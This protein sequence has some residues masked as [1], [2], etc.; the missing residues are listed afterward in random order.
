MFYPKIKNLYERNEDG[1]IDFDKFSDRSFGNIKYWEVTEKLDGMNIKIEFECG[2]L[3]SR[4]PRLYVGGKTK[5]SEIPYSII[6]YIDSLNLIDKLFPLFGNENGNK[7]KKIEIFGEGIGP[8]IQNGSLYC[9][10]YKV[11]V[12]DILVDHKWWLDRENVLSICNK[13]GM[14]IVPLINIITIGDVLPMVRSGFKSNIYHDPN[15]RKN[16]EGIVAKP[17]CE[18]LF[19]NKG[20]RVMFKLRTDYFKKG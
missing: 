1:T 16:A 18:Q 7:E 9:Q 4:D 20:E 15:N 2:Y 3:P 12:F 6:E 11:V 14:E 13:L 5:N 8:K 17:S 19:N 10:E